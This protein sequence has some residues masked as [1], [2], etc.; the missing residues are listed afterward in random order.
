MIKLLL[1]PMLLIASQADLS[2]VDHFLKDDTFES[3]FLPNE[4]LAMK[5]ESCAAN[6]CGQPYVTNF[7]VKD[8][9]SDQAIVEGQGDNGSPISRTSVSKEDWVALNQNRVR[10]EV[11][12]LSN[13]GYQVSVESIREGSFSFDQNGTIKTVSTFVVQL[14]AANSLKMK[15]ELTLEVAPNIG[16]FGQLLRKK[17]KR[18]N[19]GT[20]TFTVVKINR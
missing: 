8:V 2:N 6:H 15:L 11:R 9:T 14:V 1:L 19:L 3:S 20:D 10:Y 16:G 12:A 13:A 18:G 7:I 5:T 4:Q 17:Y